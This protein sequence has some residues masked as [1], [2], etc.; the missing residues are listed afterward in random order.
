M[1]SGMT[2]VDGPLWTLYVE[3]KIYFIVM[4]VALVAFGRN[5]VH[6]LAG[7]GVLA[8][9]IWSIHGD[10]NC[11]LFAAV[12][13]I[14]SAATAFRATHATACLAAG[15]VL[16]VALLMLF[17]AVRGSNVMDSGVTRFSKS[18]V[19]SSMRLSCWSRRRSS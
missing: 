2:I 16:L 7:V 5:G 19:A 18:P 14:G 10:Y 3:V 15:C 6:R 13:L 12:W 1:Q 4:G 9:G 8:A 11:G 17:G